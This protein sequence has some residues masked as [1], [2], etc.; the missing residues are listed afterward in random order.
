MLSHQKYGS[1][2]TGTLRYISLNRKKLTCVKFVCL[3]YSSWY[4]T[5]QPVLKYPAGFPKKCTFF[6]SKSFGVLP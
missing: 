4:K 1:D 5:S 6:R 3:F 2:M